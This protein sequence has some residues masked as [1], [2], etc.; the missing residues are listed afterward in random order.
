M[1]TIMKKAVSGVEVSADGSIFNYKE[2][3]SRNYSDYQVYGPIP[4][5]ETL[6]YGLIQNMGWQ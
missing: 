4:Y 5:Y 2:V 3:E 6:K 1:T